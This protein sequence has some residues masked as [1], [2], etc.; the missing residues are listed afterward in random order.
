[1]F[2]SIHLEYLS[3][4]NLHAVEGLLLLGSQVLIDH[5]FLWESAML[6]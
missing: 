4:R 5:T 2:D 1:M 6:L 3:Q